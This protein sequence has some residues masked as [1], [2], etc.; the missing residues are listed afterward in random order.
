VYNIGYTSGI[1]STVPAN[2]LP[3]RFVLEQNYPNPFNPAT[4]IRYSIPAP[5]HVTLSVYNVTGQKVATLVNEPRAAGT[6]EVTFNGDQL[7]G[8]IYFYRIKSGAF[9]QIRKMVLLK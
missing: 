9:S 8:G 2:Q 7:S 1:G 4:V 5:G 6:Y 3:D